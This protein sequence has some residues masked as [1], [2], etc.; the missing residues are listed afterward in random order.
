MAQEIGI[1]ATVRVRDERPRNAE[2]ARIPGER[3]DAEL[4]QLP[5]VARRQVVTHLANLFVDEIVI[6]EQPF[7]RR[8]DRLVHRRGCGGRFI[9]V[10]QTA[11][12]VLE[13]RGQRRPGAST[14]QDVLRA[15]QA[16]RMLHQ[17]LLAE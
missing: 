2:H 8:R 15:R 6:V 4:G 13:P 12:V 14:G 7:G 10:H 16:P 3:T 5:V 17:T 11:R 9:R 1:E